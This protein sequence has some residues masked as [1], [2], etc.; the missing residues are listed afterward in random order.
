[1]DRFFDVKIECL[2]ANKVSVRF[3]SSTKVDLWISQVRAVRCSEKADIGPITG[4]YIVHLDKAHPD[5][6][7]KIE[8]FGPF[9]KD[10][11]EYS[12]LNFVVADKSHKTQFNVILPIDGGEAEYKQEHFW[13]P[14]GNRDKS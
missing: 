3:Y 7:Y 6:N 5:D 1:M 14:I 12:Y 8:T 2:E 9:L 11:S 13:G 4:Y 10:Y